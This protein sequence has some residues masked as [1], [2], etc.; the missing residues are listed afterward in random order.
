VIGKILIEFIENFNKHFTVKIAS[1]VI[2]FINYIVADEL[3]N[4]EE[5]LDL[6]MDNVRKKM[7]SFKELLKKIWEGKD[8]ISGVIVEALDKY[9][10]SN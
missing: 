8:E 9:I 2:W 3:K 5:N 10:K 1:K 7:N 6:N 4:N